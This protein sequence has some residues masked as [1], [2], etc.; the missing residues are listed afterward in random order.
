MTTHF[1]GFSDVEFI[2]EG[3][4]GRVYR[5]VRTSTS[6]VVALKEIK[7]LVDGSPA[8]RRAKREVEALVR[9]KGH[10]HVVSVEEVLEG[11]NGPLLVMEY[12]DAG[13]VAQLIQRGPVP[14][15][16]C[17]RIGLAV[18]SAVSAAH[19]IGI[20]HRDLK[21]HNVLLGSFGQIKVCDFGIAAI[22]REG[23]DNTKTNSSTLAY[24]SPE[25][26]D[27]S[28]DVG[29]PA[30]VYSFSVMFT[31]LLNG[32]RPTHVERGSADLFAG[33]DPRLAPL[34][35]LLRAGMAPATQARPTVD[36]LIEAMTSAAEAVGAAVS[37]MTP[38][39]AASS[40]S[41]SR[42]ATPADDEALHTRVRTFQPVAAAPAAEPAP[43]PQLKQRDARTVPLIVLGLVALAGVVVLV[44]GTTARRG[45]FVAFDDS[46]RVAIYKGREGGLLWWSPTRDAE[47]SHARDQ[48]TG[49]S[50][51]RV[52]EHHRFASLDAATSW[53]A[54]NITPMT[55]PQPPTE[56][57]A[58]SALERGVAPGEVRLTWEAPASDGGS[59]IDA[60]RVERADEL[61]A[62]SDE[63]TWTEI[64]SIEATSHTASGLTAGA[65]Y[66]FRVVADNAIGASDPSE[67][68]V[69][70]AV[71]APGSP[72]SLTVSALSAN[73]VSLSWLPPR[74][75][76]GSPVTGYRVE[77][78]VADGEWEL[79]GDPTGRSFDD[80]GLTSGIDYSY[81]VAA[82]NV[83]D[84]GVPSAVVTART[85]S[86]PGAPT[87][88]E[89]L[90][91]PGLG[92]GAGQIRLIWSEP[93]SD[94]GSAITHYVI[95]RRVPGAEWETV[96]TS[97]GRVSR[98]T[99]SDNT[100]GTTYEFR[101][102]AVNDVGEGSPSPSL[103]ATAIGT[104]SAPRDPRATTAADDAAGDGARL[105]PG[106]IRLTWTESR[107]DGGSPVMTYQ[108]QRRAS[109]LVQLDGADAEWEDVDSTDKL[110]I[111]M[112]GHTGGEGYEFR[113]RARSAVGEGDWSAVREVI[114]AGLPPAPPTVVLTTAPDNGLNAGEVRVAWTA[115][116]SD[117]GS[118]ITAYRVERRSGPDDAA[119]S[120]WQTVANMPANETVVVVTDNPAETTQQF[121]VIA[122]NGVG[123]GPPSA[124]QRTSAVGLPAA[125]TLLAVRT[126]MDGEV[127]AGAVQLDW[128]PPTNTG[129][130]RVTEYQVERRAP[131]SDWEPVGTTDGQASTFTVADNVPG[132]EYEFRVVA[133]NAVGS[134]S[135]SNSASATA[136]GP[137][138]APLSLDAKP[139]WD[140]G[141]LQD[142]EVLLTW[143]APTH[144]GGLGLDS[145][146]VEQREA[147]G[148][149]Q[150]VGSRDQTNVLIRG[151]MSGVTYEFRVIAVNAAGE[152]AS[153][154]S[155]SVIAH[156]IPDA[157]TGLVAD[158]DPAN[159]IAAG[160][161]RLTWQ[162]PGNTGGRPIAEYLV[163][164]LA[165]DGTEL[166]LGETDELSFTATGLVAGQNYAFVVYANNKPE[167]AGDDGPHSYSGPSAQAVATPLGPPEAPVALVAVAAPAEG[168]GPGEVRLH[169]EPPANNGGS[170][171]IGYWVKRLAPDGDWDYI[172]GP[173]TETVF[174]SAGNVAGT[175]YGFSVLAGTEAGYGP[176]I[177][178]SITAVGYPDAP[179]SVVA[180]AAPNDGVNP[181]EVRLSWGP[182]AN[183]GGQPISFY[184]VERQTGD[185]GWEGIGGTGELSFTAAG[186]TPGLAYQFR[187]SAGNGVLASD[188]SMA[189]GPASETATAVVPEAPGT[190]LSVS[191]IAAPN[192]ALPE[193]TVRIDWQAPANDGGTPI[194]GYI[195][196]RS[197][198]GG[199]WEMISN[200]SELW[201]QDVGLVNGASYWYQVSTSNGILWSAASE[202]VSA[203][204]TT[205]PV[206]SGRAVSSRWEW[207]AV[208]DDGFTTD[209]ALDLSRVY[210]DAEARGLGAGPAA[211]ENCANYNST[212][213]GLVKATLSV[214][215]TSGRSNPEVG[216]DLAVVGD[217]TVIGG[218]T[219]GWSC[220]T[221]G[222]LGITWNGAFPNGERQT[223][224]AWIIVPGFFT[225][226]AY[227]RLGQVG[228]RLP[229]IS[230]TTW[231]GTRGW[232]WAGATFTLDSLVP[233][234]FNVDSPADCTVTSSTLRQGAS[235]PDIDCLESR[236]WS[237]TV[238]PR[239]FSVDGNFDAHTAAVLREFQATQGLTA[240]GVAGAETLRALGLR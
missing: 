21:P 169:W 58:H 141:A 231:T 120:G 79:I 95:Q 137:P 146:R 187:V 154:P 47:A 215:N 180:L 44:L 64:A 125:P 128:E 181:D 45:Y 1:E 78:A 143:N 214:R 145:Y 102:I 124:V 135:P 35:E 133:H 101:L 163:H 149:W 81:R 182:P 75:D 203:S 177:E 31:Q 199:P 156:G 106:A 184:W 210:T 230:G 71:G 186:L 114:A 147:G 77:R 183:D 112:P 195:V 117:G 24:A 62:G 221:D 96:G 205:A 115:P 6:G 85:L 235:G 2:D 61:A 160:D 228:F 25:E 200:G 164:V 12:L 80:N 87:L 39:P 171:V 227:E 15:N 233:V 161:V 38:M 131:E 189:T 158:V 19:Q 222:R 151:L 136:V 41:P 22:A 134:S 172:G 236:L 170:P 10:P 190:P 108:V 54:E 212:Q 76:G 162:P 42:A 165:D 126:T 174:V 55:R 29:A 89:L 138:D 16:E 46:G 92:L 66:Q 173:V 37:A 167:L 127:P 51:A 83:V 159:G 123:D 59:P 140:G 36:Q 196:E 202:P 237:I 4:L 132:T 232:N 139:G 206:P 175:T 152:S 211:P 34:A 91:P 18:L 191:A 3:G 40:P 229:N 68:I 27:E 90:T 121:R 13:N 119:A 53:I 63:P 116:T 5:A 49:Q 111:L 194:V 74:S 93:S 98:S 28:P 72:Q 94:G 185:G 226:G 118:P 168:L 104:P 48:L 176:A 239:K 220:L 9:L 43:A 97:D 216:A 142:G 225:D 144:D 155:A 26:L 65:E 204:P 23:A 70:I 8:W 207:T 57:T 17:L 122:T 67:S 130:A 105:S 7:V 234:Q 238:G 201:V 166:H 150:S 50:I 33:I 20:I 110:T 73:S 219:D 82:T 109:A 113:V 223:F 14:L 52:D 30:D 100:T 192:G 84:S 153:S 56:L 107:S 224:D 197:V 60:Y 157:P 213:D 208:T 88:D 218:Y 32:Y 188:G 193:G 217:L 69:A 99:V 11:P 198:D 179:M 209:L 148:E 103:E 86:A 178:T 129:G 240:D